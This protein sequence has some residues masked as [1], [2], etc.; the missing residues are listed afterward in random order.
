M[1]MGEIHSVDPKFAFC[2][3]GDFDC[4]HS[5]WLGSRFTNAYGVAAFDFTTLTDCSQLVRW[6]THRGGGILDLVLTDLVLTG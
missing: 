1:A 6:P 2:F 4:H 5:E 3:M